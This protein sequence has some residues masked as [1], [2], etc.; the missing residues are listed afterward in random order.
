VTDR[1]RLR[2]V[3]QLL[4]DAEDSLEN[5]PADAKALLR[6]AGKICKELQQQQ[7]RKAS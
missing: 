1:E 2:L 3:R 4:V 6:A 5:Y 7:E